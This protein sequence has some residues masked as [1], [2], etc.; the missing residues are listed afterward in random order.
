MGGPRR[1][2]LLRYRVCVSLRLLR[3]DAGGREDELLR[4]AAHG[5]LGDQPFVGLFIVQIGLHFLAFEQGRKALGALV[6]Q[7]ADFIGR[8]S[9]DR[10]A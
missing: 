3:R 4:Q 1:F 7:N 9:S 6:R 10:P 5:A 8:R 2:L